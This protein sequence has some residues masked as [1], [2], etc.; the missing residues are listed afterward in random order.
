MSKIVCCVDGNIGAGKSTV[1]SELRRRG[2]YVF[3]E[4]LDEWGVYLDAFYKD[5][6]KHG[7]ILQIAILCSMINEYK[8]MMEAP[9]KLVFVER[10][11]ASSII[12]SRH[13]H[14]IGFLSEMELK[15]VERLYGQLA[16]TPTL[17]LFLGVPVPTCFERMHMRGRE[18]EK[19]LDISYLEKLDEEY[20][21]LDCT[22][23][24]GEGTTNEIA[25]RIVS[26]VNR[27]LDLSD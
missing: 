5:P 7:F 18:C 20:S 1:L 26:E 3:Q 9:T 11:P 23:I 25:D 12:F 8:K 22:T 4:P 24:N 16:W 15:T 27:F 19:G 10:S 14:S 17:S 13:M 6:T 21:N 2:Y